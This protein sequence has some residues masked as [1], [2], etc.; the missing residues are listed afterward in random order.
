MKAIQLALAAALTAQAVLA[1][2]QV[3]YFGSAWKARVFREPFPTIAAALATGTTP[4]SVVSISLAD[5]LGPVLPT[6]FGV[7]TTFRTGS[8]VLGRVGLY[9]QGGFGTF[10]WPAGSGSNAY[11]WDGSIPTDLTLDPSKIQPIDGSRAS[12][13]NPAV[14]A[15]FLD[16]TNAQAN[17]VVNYFY[18]RYGKT[19]EDSRVGAT[20][21]TKRAAR[22][23]QAADYAAGLVRKMNIELKARIVN[24]EI[25]NECY[26]N[27]EQGFSVN[28]APVTGKEYGEDF[29][30]FAQAMKAV[31]PTIKV[32][33]VVGWNEAWT[34]G[35]LPEVEDAADFLILHEYVNSEKNANAAYV[36]GTVGNFKA[37][38]DALNAQV[39]KY[40]GKPSGHY[41]IALTE[42]NSSG[43]PTTNMING[44]FL[45]QVLGELVQN[46]FGL[47]TIWVGE[48]GGGTEAFNHGIIATDDPRQPAHTPR[49]GYMPFH[50]YAKYFGD[51][52]VRSTTTGNGIHAYASTFSKGQVG[53]V[54]VNTT[55]GEQTIQIKTN[56]NKFHRAYW[57]DMSAD[58]L[59]SG[60][61]K[62]QVNGKSGTSVG[63]GPADFASIP[64]YSAS[65][66][67]DAILKV[68]KYSA[69][70]MAL[71]P[72]PESVGGTDYPECGALRWTL[73]SDRTLHLEGLSSPLQAASLIDASGKRSL[74]LPSRTP[75]NRG[76]S[77]LAVPSHL[78]GVQILHLN[79]ADGTQPSLVLPVM[80]R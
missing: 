17:V 32:G 31:D 47:A 48:W 67:D 43:Y 40:T 72:V 55:G 36:L 21:A 22:V 52:M 27:W 50:F 78:T 54:I 11:F 2:G 19:L 24:W 4:T 56:S 3:G 34:S 35:V 58:N 29:R 80:A 64:A 46:H 69:V 10:R 41:P 7:N 12:D 8:G 59:D 49:P 9:R 38:S 6:Q 30:V 14:F 71:A 51:R 45:A 16:S 63:G 1:Q 60:N 53:L 65:F 42:F 37:I 75:A 74:L 28:G 13:L 20:Q 44:L 77:D 68:K 79:L 39:V 33:A 76:Q 18:A 73:G 61:T 70:F 66:A 26:G 25:G 15:K 5:I 23:K 57:H 62:F